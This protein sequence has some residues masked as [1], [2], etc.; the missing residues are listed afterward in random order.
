[1][2]LH[3]RLFR[4]RG[5]RKGTAVGP[6]AEYS[7]DFALNTLHETGQAPGAR[8]ELL[9]VGCTLLMLRDIMVG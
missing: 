6:F 4:G 1:V 3:D 7:I 2:P 5:R 9:T 8:F